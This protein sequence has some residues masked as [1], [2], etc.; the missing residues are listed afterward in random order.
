MITDY[1]TAI[2]VFI[3]AIYAYLTHR[4]AVAS[5]SSVRAVMDQ[6][7]AMMR[8]YVT[9]APLIRPQV[10][11]F[12]LR[13]T[14]TGRTGAENL[15]LSLDKDFFQRGAIKSPESNLRIKSAFTRPIDSFPPE[16]ELLFTLG[17]GWILFGKDAKPDAT[18]LQFNVTATYEF[19]KRKVTE[20]TSV[21]LRPYLGSEG[22][23]D[24]LVE[25]IE[26][27]RK[28]IENRPA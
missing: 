19:N 13:I 17:P 26:K 12:Y 7:E 5:E 15:C 18:P 25:E 21:D 4:M 24:Q 28:T 3:T 20:I 1:L 8:P 14:N 10:L 2:L 9:I 6:S 27:L 22:A 23:H 16:A 11:D